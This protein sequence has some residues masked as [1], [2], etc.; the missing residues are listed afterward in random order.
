MAG[1]KQ[2]KVSETTRFSV[3]LHRHHEP[4]PEAVVSYGA[5]VPPTNMNIKAKHCG[6]M[7]FAWLQLK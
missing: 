2:K 7:V 1:Q 3:I 5:F 4:V 6:L